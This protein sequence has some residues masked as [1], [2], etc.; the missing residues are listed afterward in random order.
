MI[1][2]YYKEKDTDEI[3]KLGSLL[4]KD[5]KLNLDEFSNCF[6]VL[7]KLK[8]VGFITYSIMYERSEIVDLIVTEKE[9]NK[10]YGTLL[11]GA[12]INEAIRAK[13]DN[14]TLE[15]NEKNEIA[16][17]LYKKKG[18]EIVSTRKNYYK[19]EDGYL[20]KLDLR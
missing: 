15:V 12:I 5:Y 10:N 7:D 18:F 16:I 17:N 13:C 8:V 11:V 6:V 14:I 1:I 20:M 4:H 19:D 3:N 2:R 9:R